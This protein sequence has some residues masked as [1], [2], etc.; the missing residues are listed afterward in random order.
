MKAKLLRIERFLCEMESVIPWSELTKIIRPYYRR[1]SGR[2][3]HDL[4]LMLRIHFGSRQL[5][6]DFFLATLTI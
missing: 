1:D 3:P 5:K 2:P 6:A 4:L